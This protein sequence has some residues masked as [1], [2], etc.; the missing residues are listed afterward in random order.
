MDRAIGKRVFW[1][2]RTAKA[3]ISLRVRAVWSGPMLST[4]WINGYYRM[5]HWRAKTRMRSR[6]CAV[7]CES[8]HFVH[9]RRHF[10]IWRGTYYT[11]QDEFILK[12]Y[13]MSRLNNFRF[14]EAFVA[15]IDWLQSLVTTFI[16][17]C[18]S[19]WYNH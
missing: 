14:S 12:N 6:A 7:W 5:Y 3:Q 9:A 18:N 4:A 17:T 10:S 16:Y 2:M 13:F 11:I 8:A 19:V 1:H 15:S